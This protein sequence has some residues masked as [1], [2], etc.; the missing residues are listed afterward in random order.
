MFVDHFVVTDL[1]RSV[2]ILSLALY[3]VDFCDPFE[4]VPSPVKITTSRFV[5]AHF[6]T[7]SL[8]TKNKNHLN[9][10]VCERIF[11]LNGLQLS[12]AHDLTA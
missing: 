4:W 8:Q 1:A 9:A 7:T 3:H 10:V 2:Y 6:K 11:L 5:C 12:Y